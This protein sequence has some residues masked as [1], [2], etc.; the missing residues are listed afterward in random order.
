VS[1]T[2]YRI[3]FDDGDGVRLAVA[4]GDHLGAAIGVAAARLGRNRPVWPVAAAQA[5]PGDVPLGESVGKGVVVERIAPDTLEVSRRFHYPSGVVA[6][7]GGGPRPPLVTG[8]IDRSGDRASGEPLVLEAVVEGE[9]ARERFL[10]VVERLPVVDNIEVQVADHFDGGNTEV[11]LT[12]RLKDPRRALRFLDDFSLDLLDNGHVDVAVYVREPRST[13]RL[14]QHKTLLWM[15]VDDGLHAKVRAWLE[16]AGLEARDELATIAGSPHHHYRPAA[17]SARGKL[18]TRLGK[19]GM[20][21]VD[22]LKPE[23]KS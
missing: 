6:A 15:S 7:L 11:W 16:H 21:K 1:E 18:E 8:F 3:A 17:A 12:P 23:T 9:G 2:W 4:P 14:T 5:P 10:E 22:T 20:R 13:F 19:A